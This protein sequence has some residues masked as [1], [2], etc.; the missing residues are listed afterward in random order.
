MRIP[1]INLK[2]PAGPHTRRCSRAMAHRRGLLRGKVTVVVTGTLVLTLLLAGSVFFSNQTTGL[3]SKMA[4]LESRR[5]FLEAG[6]GQLLTR[7]KAATT[8]KVIIRRAREEIGL[9]VQENPGLVLV[10]RDEKGRNGAHDRW[11]RFLS[12]FGGGGAAQAAVD[13]TGLVVGSMV[14]L[15]PRNASM[16]DPQ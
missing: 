12:R 5:E 7:W 16:D 1:D 6:A 13:Q 15:T 4:E 14:S 3:R 10:C 2:C 9:E 11:R 8:A